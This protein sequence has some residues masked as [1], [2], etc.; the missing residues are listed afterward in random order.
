ML[1]RCAYN[2]ASGRRFAADA[3]EKY[4]THMNI[5]AREMWSYKLFEAVIEGVT[6]ESGGTFAVEGH[7]RALRTD[8]PS[9]SSSL[10]WGALGIIA[11]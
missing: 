5:T 2:D 10:L 9:R 3:V 4:A 11:W 7:L 1:C 8:A 6:A